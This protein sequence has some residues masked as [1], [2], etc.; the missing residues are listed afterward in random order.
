MPV[1]PSFSIF[2]LFFCSFGM[3]RICGERF[4]GTFMIRI[5]RD[6]YEISIIRSA[7][8]GKIALMRA[9]IPHPTTISVS[10]YLPLSTLAAVTQT[11]CSPRPGLPECVL[12]R[13]LFASTPTP[14][15]VFAARQ[16]S[17][18]P[19][20][21]S[22]PWKTTFACPN[23]RLLLLLYPLLRSGARLVAECH[24]HEFGVAGCSDSAKR[25]ADRPDAS[26]EGKQSM[27][28]VG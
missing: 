22:V 1:E 26:R 2:L 8:L 15:S 13:H 5:L 21:P 25:E 14:S 28:V 6:E 9:T 10:P 20:N 7:S 11:I 18:L 23:T 24:P 19:L 3:R 16:T 17:A 4:D 12:L 27:A